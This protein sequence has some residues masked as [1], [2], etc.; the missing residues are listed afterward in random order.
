ME[1]IVFEVYKDK[2]GEHRWRIKSTNG[3]IIGTSGEGYKNAEDC[4]NMINLIMC[5]AETASVVQVEE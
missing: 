3:N 2:A 4:T 5:C 1:S